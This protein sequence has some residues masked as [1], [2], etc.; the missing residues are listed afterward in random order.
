MYLTGNAAPPGGVPTGNE[1]LGDNVESLSDPAGDDFSNLTLDMGLIPDMYEVTGTDWNDA[2][3]N[4]LRELTESGIAGVTVVLRGSPWPGA[5]ERC[6]S[7]DTDADGFYRFDSVV[8]GSYQ[9]IESDA[10]SVPFGSASCP[11]AESDPA[12]SIS[13]TPN[14]RNITVYETNLN[15][16]DFGDIKKPA[17]SPDHQSQ[18]VPGNVV[19]YA[20]KFSSPSAGSVVFSH[21]SD[22]NNS[23]SWSHVLYRDSNCDGVLNGSEAN[24]PLATTAIPVVANQDICLV[25]KVYAGT[26]VPNTDQYRVITE[27]SFTSDGG[28]A[29]SVELRVTDL[30]IASQTPAEETGSRLSLRKSVENIT[31]GTPETQTSNSALPGDVLKYRLY[32][33]NT[34]SAALTELQINDTPP[35]H[36]LIRLGTASCDQTPATLTCTPVTTF[37]RVDWDVV[38][39]LGAGEGGIVS[40]EVEVDQ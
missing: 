32:Y 5:P 30:T 35:M 2:D 34:G 21:S 15:G 10:S 25:N 16:Q 28:G 1:P 11:P 29:G 13:T 7:V 33:T 26:S 40:Y 36:T 27:A 8:P 14:T 17:F 22:L 12:G 24:T 6:V 20:H 39:A 38:G 4:G 18:I 31:Q 9:L 19:F 23:P 37:D 3:K